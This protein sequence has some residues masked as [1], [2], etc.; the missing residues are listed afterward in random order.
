MEYTLFS[1]YFAKSWIN[2]DRKYVHTAIKQNK[3]LICLQ[4][5]DSGSWITWHNSIKFGGKKNEL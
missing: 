4:S 2:N 3:F 5:V 1:Q